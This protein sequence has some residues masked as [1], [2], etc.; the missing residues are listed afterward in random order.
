M[1]TL[2]SYEPNAPHLCFFQKES[3]DVASLKFKSAMCLGNLF[4]YKAT[5]TVKLVGCMERG[6]E[7][8]VALVIIL[9]A[10]I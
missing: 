8:I 3:T 5:F 1:Y 7:A 2:E 4:L 6:H 10:K 9:C